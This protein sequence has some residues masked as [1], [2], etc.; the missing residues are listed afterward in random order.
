MTRLITIVFLFLCI[1][2]NAQNFRRNG[3][4]S[5]NDGD[6][7]IQYYQEGDYEKAA[8]IFEK[9]FASPNNEAYF[10]IYFNT[11]LKLKKL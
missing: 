5:P 10:D 6:L 4:L 8:V 2:V 9:L 1:Q 3:Q 7:A 11:L